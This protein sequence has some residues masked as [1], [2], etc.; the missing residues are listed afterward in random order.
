MLTAKKKIAVR[1]PIKESTFTTKWLELRLYIQEN[2]KL[3]SGITIGIIAIVA[4]T[5]IYFTNK[6]TENVEASVQLAS[7]ISL[8]EQQ[9]YK[10]AIEGDPTRRLPGLKDISNNFS[11]TNSASVANLF[12]GNSYLYLGQ[13]DNAISAYQNSDPDG[14]ILKAGVYAGLGM[15]YEGKK[16]FLKAAQYF[17]QAAE[18]FKEDAISADRLMQ[19]A[20]NYTLAGDK[21]KA[22]QL[23]E[24]ILNDY[25]TMRYSRDIQR[26]LAQLE[27]ED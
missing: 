16:E 10:L 22:K 26:Y 17:E 18:E 6:K 21:S 2:I 23:Y 3:I 19:A 12:L 27:I 1:E 15:A 24:S 5:Y 25:K 9:Q 4:F 13:F 11:G 7:V 14:N 20:R 8:Y